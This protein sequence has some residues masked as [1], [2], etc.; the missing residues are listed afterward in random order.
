MTS[1]V[2]S[3]FGGESSSQAKDESNQKQQTQ[4]DQKQH[5]SDNLF[6]KKIDVPEP[7]VVATVASRPPLKKQQKQ[8]PRERDTAAD[9]RTIFVGN[10]PVSFATKRRRLHTLFSECGK[11]QSVRI[12]NVATKGVKLP[13]HQAGNQQL[14][15]QVASNT[16]QLLEN[17]KQC[18]CGYV[19]FAEEASVE[20]AM[21]KNHTVVQDGNVTRHIR[22]DRASPKHDAS[23]TVFVGNLPYT[24]DEE[25]LTQ[26]F[27]NGLGT[28]SCVENV[29]IVRDKD[30]YQCKG[31]AYVLFADSSF[32][33]DALQ[34]CHDTEYLGRTLRVQVCGTKYKN[35]TANHNKN[36]KMAAD[37]SPANV[38]GAVRRI[39][40]AESAATKKKKRGR[41]KTT[42]TATSAG[43][44]KRAAKQA[45][46][47]QRV[48]KLEKRLSKGM[49]K[50][51]NKT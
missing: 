33:A 34:K 15:K 41:G 20:M 39:L 44:S 17:T 6:D 23:R 10:L 32:R 40:Q 19:V 28:A 50:Q 48:K 25:S 16:N 47:N 29:R 45:K 7:Q 12:R 21:A 30:T 14:V 35:A 2:E 31:F 43:S 38:A 49:G 5:T 46:S 37:H 13:E 9:A 1:L 51:K 26:H 11:I 24:S 36:K 42:T 22:V 8:A 18:V 4:Q 3:L 27:E